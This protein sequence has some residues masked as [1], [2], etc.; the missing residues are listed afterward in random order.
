MRIKDREKKQYQ[1]SE[2]DYETEG[3]EESVVH[4]QYHKSE[5]YRRS[6]PYNLHSRACIK[7]EDICISIRIACSAY[8]YPSKNK[9]AKVYNNRNPIKGTD[10]TFSVAM[11]A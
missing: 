9:K 8:T 10:Y 11:I 3:V 5:A 7:T 1:Q 2:I 6:Y 4:H